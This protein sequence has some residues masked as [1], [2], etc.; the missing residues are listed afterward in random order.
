MGSHVPAFVTHEVAMERSFSNEGVTS[1]EARSS[2]AA[3][4]GLLV[5]N[6]ALD[7]IEAILAE[8][9]C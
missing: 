4:G 8:A 2:H 5:A 6:V 7:T 9:L 3:F 1:G